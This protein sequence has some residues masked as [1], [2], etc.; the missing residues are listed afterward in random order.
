MQEPMRE[1]FSRQDIARRVAQLGG[2]ISRDYADADL[3]LVCVLGG[4][5]V[6]TADLCRSLS[7]DCGI[8][9]IRV[10]SYG[11]ATESAGTIRL[12]QEPT[13]T[14]RGKDILL[15]E[16]IVD[17]GTTLQWLLG[18][19]RKQGAA[20]VRLCTL[21]DK[22]ERRRVALAPDYAG[23]TL[24]Q[25][26]LVGYGLDFAGKYRNLPAIYTMQEAAGDD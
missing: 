21:I 3:V 24:E 19:F 5:F 12:V 18:Y 20:S 6:F 16:D 25:G 26:F 14:V 17:T 4:A 15:V 23:F 2:E 11:A 13:G 7:I 8:D 9:F 10:A 1:V 22:K